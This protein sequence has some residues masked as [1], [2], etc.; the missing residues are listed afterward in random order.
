MIFTRRTFLKTLVVAAGGVVVGGMTGCDDDSDAS[1]LPVTINPQFFPQSVASGDPKSDSIIVWTRVSDPDVSGNLSVR[2]QLASDAEFKQLVLNTSLTALA[3]HDGCVRVKVTR[4]NPR[5][6]YFYRFIY[7]KGS[8]QFASRTARCKTAPAVTEDVAVS[9]GF[10]SC[11]DYIGRYYNAYFKLLDENPDF[12]VHLGDYIYETTGDPQFQ[13][14]AAQRSIQ[15]TDESHAIAVGTGN[16]RYY[17]AASLDNYRQLYRT[18]RSDPVLQQVHETMPMIAIW[19]D[20]EFSDDCWGATAT[21]YNGRQNELSEAR[22]QAAEQAWLEYMPVDVDDGEGELTATIIPARLY[23]NNRIYRDFHFGKHLHLVMTDY[24]SYRPDHP[25][26]EDAFPYT[27]VLDQATLT[28]LLAT[29]GIPFDNVRHNFAPYLNIDAVEYASY[30]TI[31]VGV[32]TQAYI[33]EGLTATEAQQ[34]AVQNVRGHIDVNFI[35][36]A[37][38]SYNATVAEAQ[39]I[40]LLTDEQIAKLNRGLSYLF[41]GKQGLFSDVGSRYFVVKSTYDLFSSYQYAFGSGDAGQNAYGKVQETWL[42]TTLQNSS[43]TFRVVADSVSF[44]SLLLDLSGTSPKLPAE[45]AA[46]LQQLPATLRTTFYLNVDQWDGFVNKRAEWLAFLDS[47]PNTVLIAGDI[48]SNYVSKHGQRTFEFTGT[49]VSSGTFSKLVKSSAQSLQVTGLDAL[50]SQL[51]TLLL[52]SNSAINYANTS[53]CGVAIMRVDGQGVNV[54]YHELPE[55]EVF[56]SYYN[57]RN[58]LN[59]HFIRREFKISDGQL[60]RIA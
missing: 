33:K 38:Q 40:A 3:E 11:Q 31:L 17:A 19:D 58:E 18:Y 45:L 60:S 2:L 55:S 46:A 43:S 49:S 42:K 14:T 9:F 29:Q 30:R 41:M 50:L 57:N 47:L 7:T 20:H 52:L 51:D 4:L 8:Q 53:N 16:A 54:V 26:P 21:T 12:F 48:H 5:T 59:T 27:I 10:V 1:D 22:R 15:F 34:R 44:T 56:K 32:M 39:R 23:P 25:I 24:R 37:L 6:P 13:Q 35:N 28:Q 36:P